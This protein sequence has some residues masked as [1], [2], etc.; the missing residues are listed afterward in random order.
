M[1][2]L[3]FTSF[4]QGKQKKGIYRLEEVK[5]TSFRQWKVSS[6]IDALKVV[7]TSLKIYVEGFILD[8]SC[9]L[10][11]LCNLNKLLHRYL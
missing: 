6:E 11:V 5:Q 4:M 1:Y 7:A 8:E 3:Y 2:D 10:Q 9:S